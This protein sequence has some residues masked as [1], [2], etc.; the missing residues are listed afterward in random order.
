MEIKIENKTVRAFAESGRQIKRVQET[1]DTVVPD[2]NDDIGKVLSTNTELFL[3]SKDISS[4]GVVIEGE[5]EISLL[6]ITESEDAVSFV[7]A[8]KTFTIEYD[9]EDIDGDTVA[10]IALSLTNSETRVL[11]PRKVSVTI[12]IAG[13]MSCFKPEMNT[14]GTE[15]PQSEL[16]IHTRS[17]T[18]NAVLINSACEKTF[19][20]NEQFTFPSAKPTPGRLIWQKPAFE[21]TETQIIGTKAL[22]KGNMQ[23]SVCYLTDETKYPVQCSFS[24]PFSQLLDIGQER[25]DISSVRIEVSSAY[26]EII[27]TISGEKA[28]DAEIHAVLQFISFFRQ[29]ISYISDAYCNC[30]PL[31]C[32]MRQCRVNS[33]SELMFARLSS[34]ERISIA[35]DCKDVLNIQVT[36]ASAA[37]SRGKTEANIAIDVLY[38][39]EAGT[40]SVVHR[41]VMLEG[42]CA[43]TDTRMISSRLSDIYLRPDGEVLEGRINVEISYRTAAAK[44]VAVVD[45]MELDEETK[46]D[47]MDFPALTLVRAEGESV[48]ELAKKYRSSPERIAAANQLEN[49]VRG[50]LLMI[51]KS[52]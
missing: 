32:R 42:A 13:E 38:M 23:L 4:R 47:L 15:L 25:M 48:W 10:Q 43:E 45:S 14:V 7:R 33:V 12:E 46:L 20:V 50:Q 28:M 29:D 18:E 22:I 34:D 19:A 16:V 51:P 40:M 11:N 37:I 8:T 52:V 24:S 17:E 36:L 5:A 6:Y 21:V 44:E 49:G 35:E 39:T 1:I 3:K 41:G 26:F 9:V 27:D 31:S 30:A 2:T